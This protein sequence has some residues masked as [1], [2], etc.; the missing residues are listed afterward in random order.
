[1]VAGAAIHFHKV[2]RSKILGSYQRNG[3]TK[4]RLA[5]AGRVTVLKGI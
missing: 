2:A 1:M 5:D 4:R 3:P